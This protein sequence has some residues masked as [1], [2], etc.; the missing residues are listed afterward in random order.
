MEVDPPEAA[1]TLLEKDAVEVVGK[2]WY[3]RLDKTVTSNLGKYR[4]YK[5][6]SVRDLLRAMRNKVSLFGPHQPLPPYTEPLS[7]REGS[8]AQD[9]R[10]MIETPLSGSRAKREETPRRA[11]CWFLTFLDVKIPELILACS[12]GHSG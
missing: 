1:L 7:E 9:G 12:R 2:D 5:G 3:S 4:K 8:P 6:N 10:L 11:A